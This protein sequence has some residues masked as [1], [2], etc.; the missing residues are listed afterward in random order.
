MKLDDVCEVFEAP[1]FPDL[2]APE[3]PERDSVL[4][5]R[6]NITAAVVDDEFLADCISRELSRLEDNRLRRGLVPFFIVPGKGIHFAF[7]YWPPGGTPGPHEHT[8]WTITAVCRNQLDVL[9]Y[10]REE[11]YRRRE[12]VPKNRF[13]AAAGRVGFIYEPCIHEPRNTTGEWSLSLHVISPRDGER[14]VGH[15]EPLPALSFTSEP[16]SAEDDH[17]YARVIVAHYRRRFVHQLARILSSMDVPSAPHLLAQSLGLASSATRRL[18]ERTLPG[19]GC[20]DAL[21]GPWLLARTHKDLVLSD[22]YVDDM[23]ALDVE[24]ANGPVEELVISSEARDAIAFVAREPI[25][26]VSALPGSLSEDEQTAIGEVLEETG[27]F[28]RVQL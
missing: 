27:L 2:G 24:T 20:R 12:L 6:S 15:E 1:R 25:F 16:S 7:G 13:P 5:A 14:P 23:V 19:S 4:A 22:R 26:E 8:A 17:P 28:T 21:K 9:T 3:H 10:D 18:I 11:S